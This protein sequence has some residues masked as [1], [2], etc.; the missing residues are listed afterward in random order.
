LSLYLHGQWPE[1]R[2]AGQFDASIP[3]GRDAGLQLLNVHLYFVKILGCKL[4]EDSI[5][6]ELGSL[7]EAL[8]KGAG[9]PAIWLN[10]ADSPFDEGEAIAFQ[11]DVFTMRN[12]RRELD[13]LTWLYLVH[14]VAVKVSYIKPGARL[15]VP[16]HQW[17]PMNGE[18]II[19][20][21]PFKGAT[22]PVD[23]S[24]ALR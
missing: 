11:S 5:E 19:K 14:P 21:S 9:H 1:V 2:R 6:L 17:N 20:L 15:H 10:V 24:R 16:G 3:F 23:G 8:V 18:T 13:G 22:E 12:E 7:A 4:M